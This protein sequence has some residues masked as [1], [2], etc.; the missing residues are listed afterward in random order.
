V[1]A[2]TQT[3]IKE[4]LSK[5]PTGNTIEVKLLRKDNNKI[6]GKLMLIGSESFEVQTAQ[7]GKESTEKIGFADVK[8]VKKGGMKMSSKIGIWMAVGVGVAVGVAALIY[9]N[10]GG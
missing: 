1:V 9:V 10:H 4:Q 8:S 6:R 3:A 2:Q 5:I 7:S